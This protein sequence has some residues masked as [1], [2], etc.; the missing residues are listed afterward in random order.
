MLLKL[1]KEPE[2]KELSQE[3][4]KLVFKLGLSKIQ[5]SLLM[6]GLVIDPNEVMTF[7]MFSYTSSYV[8]TFSFKTF[9]QLFSFFISV[10]IGG[11][12]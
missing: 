5:C 7:W 4:S 11:C 9:L 8:Q 1:E 3:S 12:T 6:N 2:L 10:G